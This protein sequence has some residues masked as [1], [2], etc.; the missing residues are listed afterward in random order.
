MSRLRPL[1]DPASEAALTR[2]DAERRFLALIRAAKL[3]LPRVNTRLGAH[4]VDFVWTQQRLA[5][6]VDGFRYHS[7][8]HAFERDRAR[9]V[10]IAA[11][12][13]TVIRATWHQIVDE[14]FALVA[15]FAQ[16]L[17]SAG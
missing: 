16:A 7:S 14:P 2:S 12:G 15:R 9:D 13:Y 11:L 3:P 4:E 8:R 17:A 10:D 6:E 5:V 1:V